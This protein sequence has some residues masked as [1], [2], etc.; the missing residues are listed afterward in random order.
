VRRFV[1]VPGSAGPGAPARSPGRLAVAATALTGAVLLAIGCG[2]REG[3]AASGS[4]AP[5]GKVAIAAADRPACTRLLGNLEQVTHTLNASSELIAS[6][7]DKQ[8][9]AVRIAGEVSQL[10]LAAALMA[11]GPVPAP[12]AAADR[13]LV[14]GL[15]T[16]ADDY[17][18]ASTAASAGDLRTAVAEMTDEATVQ[19]IVAASTT[20]E[21]SCR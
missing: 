2:P 11:Q 13:D 1:G 5:S 16:L 3:S 9:L 4:P 10:Q 12:L 20:I 6:S 7:L 17:G 8:Q 19:R 21:A 15:R 14:A 18:R